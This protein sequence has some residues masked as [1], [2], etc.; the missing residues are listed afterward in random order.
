MANEYVENLTKLS[1]SLVKPLTDLTEL[2]AKT[3]SKIA[4]NENYEE[5]LQA[6]EPKEFMSA[7][8]KLANAAYLE[9]MKHSQ[10]AFEIVMNAATQSGKIVEEILKKA[11]IKTA[12]MAQSG[13][14]KVKEK[15]QGQQ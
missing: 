7:Q 4:K 2:N 1:Q 9:T 15:A 14:N 13:F 6:K 3:I 10:E 12:D 11:T 8:F 5:L